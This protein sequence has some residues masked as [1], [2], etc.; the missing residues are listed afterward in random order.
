MSR[1]D[2][3]AQV[4]VLYRDADLLVLD[5][6]SGL[7][8]TRPDPGPSLVSVARGLDPD[9]T[10]LHPSSRLDVEVTGVV[11]FARTERATAH[12]LQ[13]RELGRYTRGYLALVARAP[14]SEQGEWNAAIGIDPRDRTLRRVADASATSAKPA[15]T[16]YRVMWQRSGCA[17]L[18][19]QPHTG[20]TH[21]LRVHAAHAGSPI[22]GD[23]AYGG[24]QRLVLSDGRAVAA[25]RTLLHC[26]RVTIPALEGGQALVLEAPVPDDMLGFARAVGVTLEP[27]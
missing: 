17:A 23:R 9:A 3:S 11:T 2:P 5:K 6:P 4:R 24:A 15:R 12:L 7:P 26:A 8:T 20:R 16:S 13:A 25:R 21:Q 14:G 1:P 18:W 22:Y 19:L 10:R 27:G